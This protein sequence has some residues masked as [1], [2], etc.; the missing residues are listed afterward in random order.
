MGFFAWLFRLKPKKIKL[1][2][3]LGSGGAKGYAHLGA[4]R[5]FEENGVEFDVVAG[6]SIGSII[7]A[8]YA[9]GYTSN[10]ISGLLG[11]LGISELAGAVLSTNGLQKIIDEALGGKNIEELKKPFV[12]IATEV[13]VGDEY[14]FS[15]GSVSTAL[16]ASSSMPPYFK[17][18]VVGNK[19]YI[20]GAFT[21]SVPA[22]RVMEMGADYVVGID[23]SSHEPSTGLVKRFYPT[24]RNKTDTPWEKGYEYSDVM[25][26]PNLAAEG[27]TSISFK[28][29]DRVRMYDLGYKAAMDAMPKILADI[30][31]L[32]SGKKKKQK[33]HG[34][35]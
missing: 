18:V 6:T 28:E 32:K 22:D 33:K 21:N 2:L 14:V 26:N 5:A 7:G 19:R 11:N 16:A 35:R 24:F 30:R 27:F 9:D 3:A 10:D 20:D 15:S 34:K 1:G 4:L 29:K 23:L 25:L 12:A 13:D 31:D 17:P 8:A